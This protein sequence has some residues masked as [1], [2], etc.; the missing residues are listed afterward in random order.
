[1]SKY[2]CFISYPTDLLS[3]VLNASIF[4]YTTFSLR[5]KSKDF[6]IFEDFKIF[7]L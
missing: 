1:M 3:D 2:C 6:E 7:F 5:L 4:N